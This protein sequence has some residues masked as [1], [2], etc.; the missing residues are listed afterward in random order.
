M[1]RHYHLP[2]WL[3]PANRIIVALQRVFGLSI[4]TM[5]V[6]TVPGRKSGKLR[7]T[8]VSLM[9]H[10]KER[11]VVGGIPGADWVKNVRASGWGILSYRRKSERIRLVELPV[12]EGA[13][14]LR[15]FPRLVPHGVQ[16]FRSMYP[17]PGDSTLLPDAFEKLAPVCPVFRIEPTP[18]SGHELTRT[19]AISR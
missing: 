1:S 8:P 9:R 7:S 10:G 2:R 11:Y 6:L 16:F 13:P 12:E 18:A 14:I 5:H 15:E 17:L 19:G 4:G 3:K